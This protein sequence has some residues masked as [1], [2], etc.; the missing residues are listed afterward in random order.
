MN[1]PKVQTSPNVRANAQ[2]RKENENKNLEYSNLSFSFC[3]RS[4]R[5][6]APLRSLSLSPSR[7]QWIS[8]R[9]SSFV[10]VTKPITEGLSVRARASVS[11]NEFYSIRASRVAQCVHLTTTTTSEP[12]SPSRVEV[13]RF[14]PFFRIRLGRLSLLTQKHKHTH[15]HI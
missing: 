6:V 10:V 3:S 12:R 4:F 2:K 5:F 7:S 14:F 11:R 1:S 8:S 15:T 9:P 13:A